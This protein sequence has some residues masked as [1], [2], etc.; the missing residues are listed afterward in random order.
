MI[1][2]GTENLIRHTFEDITL[3]DLQ[4]LANK[5]TSIMNKPGLLAT[6]AENKVV[7]SQNKE[8]APACGK[9]FKEHLADFKGKGGGSDI[10]AQ[11]G[12]DSWEDAAAFYEFTSQYLTDKK[13]H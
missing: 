3:K 2:D 12:F 9:F 6:A 1:G 5:L 8:A 11:A 4:G 7:L 10:M 13:E